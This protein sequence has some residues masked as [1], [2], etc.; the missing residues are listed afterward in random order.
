MLMALGSSGSITPF[1]AIQP[2]FICYV[3]GAFR[4]FCP[5]YGERK[6]LEHY[7]LMKLSYGPFPKWI[8]TRRFLL[9]FKASTLTIMYCII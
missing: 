6:G 5:V 7:H 9:T 2:P 1:S 3:F 4:L 8:A